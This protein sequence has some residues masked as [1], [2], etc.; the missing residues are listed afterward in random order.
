MRNKLIQ[1]DVLSIIEG[2]AEIKLTGQTEEESFFVRESDLN[3][4]EEEAWDAIEES[5]DKAIND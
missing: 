5:I 4:A 3:R 2:K 1:I